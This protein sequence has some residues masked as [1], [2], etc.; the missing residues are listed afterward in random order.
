LVIYQES[1]HE[2]QSTKRKT[3]TSVHQHVI[4]RKSLQKTTPLTFT[5]SLQSSVMPAM[6]VST[7]K[8]RGRGSPVAE[9]EKI[10]IVH[11]YSF[12]FGIMVFLSWWQPSLW[13]LNISKYSCCQLFILH[14]TVDIVWQEA[15]MMISETYPYTFLITKVIFV[16]IGLCIW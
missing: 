3:L 7:V 9:S 12:N 4:T 13:F 11:Y 10:W 15:F 1:L 16:I 6:S 5:S 14:C 2:A 8:T